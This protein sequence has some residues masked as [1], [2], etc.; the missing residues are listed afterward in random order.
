VVKRKLEAQEGYRAEDQRLIFAGGQLD[1]NRTVA[2]YNIKHEHTLHLVMRLTGAP[3]EPK[4]SVSLAD[5]NKF[6]VYVQG[7]GA[8]MIVDVQAYDTCLKLKEKIAEVTGIPTYD[9][10]L[11]VGFRVMDDAQTLRFCQITS[12]DVITLRIASMD[13]P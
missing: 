11:N 13:I 1:N 8:D 12:G 6:K 3:I 9:Q 2:D 7:V 10:I 5:N 4:R